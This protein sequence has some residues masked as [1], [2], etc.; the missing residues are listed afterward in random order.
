MSIYKG[1]A[2]EGSRAASLLKKRE[3]QQ[4]ESKLKME[5]IE[6]ETNRATATISDKFAATAD[7]LEERMK[8]STYGLVTLEQMK[9]HRE[10]VEAE[11]L[12]LQTEAA[13]PAPQSQPLKKKAVQATGALSFALDED[14]D[15]DAD[16]DERSSKSQK[17]KAASSSAEDPSAKRKRF[18]KDPSVDT[19]FLPDKDRQEAERLAHERKLDELRA[20][21]EAVKQEK[22]MITYSY[23][24]G[25]GNR[26]QIELK[27]GNTISEFLSACLQDLRKEFSELRG[28]SSE[29]LIYVKEDLI[30]PHHYSFYDFIVTKARGKSGPLF[31]FDVHDDVRLE[32][33]YNVEKDE[34]HAGKVLLRGWYEHHKHIFPAS[35]WEAYDPSKKWESYTISDKK[36]GQGTH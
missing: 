3:Q 12:R 32:Q 30:I 21:R 29:S 22:I 18:G 6:K 1:S 36:A 28:V 7:N 10:A 8:V 2:S 25:S 5:Q 26:R 20:K 23:W 34:S 15:D 24:D 9:A 14:E 35:R 16:D 11:R 4:L 31:N 13:K 27:K 33:D 17:S 19:S